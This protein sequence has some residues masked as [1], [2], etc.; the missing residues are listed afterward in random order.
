MCKSVQDSLILFSTW[1][2]S[3]YG[4]VWLFFFFFSYFKQAND[5]TNSVKWNDDPL[6]L[7]RG[8]ANWALNE[9]LWS[10]LCS[11]PRWRHIPLCSSAVDRAAGDTSPLWNAI[12]HGL[13]ATVSCPSLSL[14][15]TPSNAAV[16][17]P[18]QLQTSGGSLSAKSFRLLYGGSKSFHTPCSRGKGDLLDLPLGSFRVRFPQWMIFSLQLFSFSLF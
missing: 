16:S 5:F 1:W 14:R 4:K 9:K 18:S 3:L 10:L 15:V 2:F 6:A 7:G 17:A 12:T 11:L 8:S 13:G